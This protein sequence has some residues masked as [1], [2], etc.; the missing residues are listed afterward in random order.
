MTAARRHRPGRGVAVLV[1]I[2]ALAW[3]VAAEAACF[4]AN[5]IPRIAAEDPAGF[6]RV[7]RE[8]AAMPNGE[9]VFWR[10]EA[11]GVAPSYM[12]GT[13]HAAEILQGIDPQVWTALGEARVAVFEVDA[14]QRAE[15]DARIASDPTF[16]FDQGAAPLS[17]VVSPSAQRRL[18]RA[19]A[20]RNLDMANAE[21][22]RPWL[23][24]S[25]LAFPACRLEAMS[26]GMKNMDEALTQRALSAGIPVIGLE[27]YQQAIAG[28]DRIDK[29]LLLDA[30]VSAPLERGEDEDVFRTNL[31]LYG[32]GRIAM[33][34]RL[35][36]YMMKKSAPRVDADRV[37]D[38]VMAEIL[39]F[40]N[41]AWLD[42]LTV[43]MR[44]GG[45]F[46]AVGALHMAGDKGL[47]ALLR[48]RGFRVT[49]VY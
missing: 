10:V 29:R 4:G 28:F 24:A 6:A 20:E 46:V 48:G 11:P 38:A 30:I 2:F 26:R 27:S 47:V 49:R 33:I 5:I 40:R 37:N 22:M 17:S 36:V 9:G 23:L 42:R 14:S 15:M 3:G 1:T 19:L 7:E 8:A 39:D 32:Q 12:F 31:D 35:G 25:I 34:A 13:F 18:S 44:D 21:Q 41:F 43:E 16:L 45:A